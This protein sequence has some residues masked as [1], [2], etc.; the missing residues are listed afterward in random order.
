MSLLVLSKLFDLWTKYVN[1]KIVLQV[2]GLS[3]FLRSVQESFKFVA[4][5]SFL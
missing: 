4:I 3:A 2:E 5:D 1:R